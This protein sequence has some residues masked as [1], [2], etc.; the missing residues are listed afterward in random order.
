MRTDLTLQAADG[1]ALAASF[2]AAAAP[3]GA[4]LLAGAT[5]V[6][7]RF[8]ATYAGFLAEGGL[9]VLTLDYR[10]IAESRRGPVRGDA[11][12]MQQWGALDLDAG[13]EALLARAPGL[14]VGV[15]GHSAGGWL[16]GFAS[17]APRVEALLTVASQVGYWG[18]WPMPSRLL[19]WAFWHCILPSSVALWG[20][21]P[22]FVLGGS[23]PLPA[24]VARDWARWGRRRT[25]L[26]DHARQAGANGYE[27]LEAPLR[28]YAIE[29]DL[30]APPEAVRR[31]LDLYPRVRSSELVLLPAAPLPDPAGAAP[32]AP[33]PGHFTVFR[34]TYRAA[35][36]EPQREWL[37]D[38]LAAAP[39]RP[40][41]GSPVPRGT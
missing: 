40:E 41:P 12:T 6:P 3:R 38:Q 21:L 26:R 30:Y 9:S 31:F 29:G 4:V 36:W 7:R 19:L 14:R 35:L 1:R 24:G 32:P 15:V 5:G 20:Y 16:L 27:I 10:G 28:A 11:A 13:L 8:Y 39:A 22:A 2:F 34:P 33:K 23:D 17:R 25:F 18:A 37:L